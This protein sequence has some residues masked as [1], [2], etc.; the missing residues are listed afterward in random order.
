MTVLGLRRLERDYARPRRGTVQHEVFAGSRAAVFEAG[1]KAIIQV[2][3]RS[4]T[5][6]LGMRM[7][8]YGLVATV[9]TSA[10]LPIYEE[11]RTRLR[12]PIPVA[13]GAGGGT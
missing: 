11:I 9:E 5:G 3:C 8:P 7:V 10:D 1:R 2:N 13:I 6:D 12:P 4:E